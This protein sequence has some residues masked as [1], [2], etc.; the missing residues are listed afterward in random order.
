M[1]KLLILTI[2]ITTM[3]SLLMVGCGSSGPPKPPVSKLIDLD[4]LVTD[5][6]TLDQVYAL[7]KPVLKGTS[8]LYQATKVALTDAGWTVGS[9]EG[10]F[11]ATEVGTYQVLFFKP[12]E[13]GD[14]YYMVFFKDN[15][16][17]GKSWFTYQNAYF[18]EQILKGIKYNQ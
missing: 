3:F 11:A 4:E 14:E 16:V 1:K 2:A 9:K 10:G 12:A 7:M 18:M 5:N 8:T 17:M 13:T 15:A 6:M